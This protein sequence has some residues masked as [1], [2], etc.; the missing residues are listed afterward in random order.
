V[1]VIHLTQGYVAQ[2]DDADWPGLMLYH[3][4]LKRCRSGKLYAQRNEQTPEGNRLPV[5]MHTQ[6]MNPPAGF[7][8]DHRSG[9]GLDN[10]RSNLRHATHQQ[11]QANLKPRS[12]TSSQYKGVYWHKGAGKWMAYIG[13]GKGRRYLGL[14][15]DEGLAALAYDT[16]AMITFGEFARP[17]FPQEQAA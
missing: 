3:W 8:V 5:L 7:E 17:N 2:V 14:H 15:S 12:G 4:S 11:N 6:L 10:R 1:A 9:D 16:A 13:T